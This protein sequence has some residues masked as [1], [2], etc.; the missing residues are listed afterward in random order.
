LIQATIQ[1]VSGEKYAN[2]PIPVPNYLD[3]VSVCKFLDLKV[4]Q[5]DD[6]IAKKKKLLNLLEEKRVTLI[7][8]AVTK[9]LDPTVKMNPSGVNW[10]GEIPEH[11]ELKKLKYIVNMKSGEFINADQIEPEGEYAVMGG[12]GLR[13]YTNIYTHQ[14]EFILI[15]RQGALCGNINIGEGKFYATEHAIVLTPINDICLDWLSNMLE[16]MNLSQY[17]MTAAQPGLSVDF[18][19]NLLVPVPSNEEQLV[20]GELIRCETLKIKALQ[21]EIRIAIKILLEYRIS[22]I[23]SAVT[24]KIDVRDFI[25]EQKY[26]EKVY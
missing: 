13:G 16:I 20:I 7:T 19:K 9:G 18:I 24:G 15:G 6:L 12:N 23:T 22:I 11:W 1:N 21:N 2:L 25:K 5:I 14:G 3:Q 8:Q 26:E 10:L 4:T 17:S